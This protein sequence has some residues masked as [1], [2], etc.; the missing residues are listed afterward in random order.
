MNYSNAPCARY[1]RMPTLTWMLVDDAVR[2]AGLVRPTPPE[3]RLGSARQM[4]S[5]D[6]LT[7]FVREFHAWEEIAHTVKTHEAMNNRSEGG[8]N[9]ETRE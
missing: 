8:G 6:S 5:Q 2:G 9:V 1:L 4:R 7:P 3:N